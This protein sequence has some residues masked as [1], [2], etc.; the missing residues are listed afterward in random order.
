MNTLHHAPGE[1]RAIKKYIAVLCS[2]R[3]ELKLCVCPETL[4]TVSGNVSFILWKCKGRENLLLLL[5]SDLVWQVPGMVGGCPAWDHLGCWLWS[6]CPFVVLL[7]LYVYIFLLIRVCTAPY[8]ARGTW[9]LL[10]YQHYRL[11]CHSGRETEK[12]G[13][14]NCL[15]KMQFFY[16]VL[17]I[18]L[19]DLMGSR[20]HR[21]DVAPGLG[22]T[23]T[24]GHRLH[25]SPTSNELVFGRGRI[26]D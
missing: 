5:W 15:K 6:S 25:D 7:F 1:V 19:V 18:M 23:S 21:Q 26:T 20:H 12:R 9:V 2:A 17:L 22:R 10:Q 8:R 4:E 14:G 13:R 16:H 24:R 3:A 11:I